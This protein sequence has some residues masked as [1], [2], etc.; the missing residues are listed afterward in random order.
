MTTL[1]AK[2]QAEY[3][4]A[5]GSGAIVH[6]S[7]CGKLLIKAKGLCKRGEWANW[8]ALNWVASVRLANDYMRLS[9]SIEEGKFEDWKSMSIDQA[10]RSLRSRTRKPSSI[11]ATEIEAE[12]TESKPTSSKTKSREKLSGLIHTITADANR[13][14]GSLYG[15]VS[16]S[17]NGVP[18]KLEWKDAKSE[19]GKV[20]SKPSYEGTTGAKLIESKPNR[21][22]FRSELITSGNS[23]LGEKASW[24]G[25]GLRVTVTIEIVD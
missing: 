16:G 24:A 3:K 21:M 18:I 8:L 12:T 7:N 1:I 10:L 23:G 14:A 4:K 5:S 25:K 17:E 13:V 6:A 2:I 11:P 19:I 22:A 20:L 15:F 9:M